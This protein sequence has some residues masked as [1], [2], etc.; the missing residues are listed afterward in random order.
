MLQTEWC[1]SML[2]NPGAPKH[3]FEHLLDSVTAI[4][5]LRGYHWVMGD[6]IVTL[7]TTGIIKEAQTTDA[8][9]YIGYFCRVLQITLLM[10]RFT[11]W[12]AFSS[13][14]DLIRS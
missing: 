4:T 8:S 2:T 6:L 12:F 9:L 11:L 3:V 7:L 1:I 5:G 14:N 13:S 10:N